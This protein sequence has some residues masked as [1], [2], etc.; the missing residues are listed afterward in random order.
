MARLRRTTEQKENRRFI[1]FV[2]DC[3]KDHHKRQED[4]A[5]YMNISKQAFNRR[6]NEHTPWTLTDMYKV[7]E[8]FGETY[9]L[10][11]KR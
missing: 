2:E 3:L 6:M 10:G 5:D 9:I 1:H 11:A 4:V 7:C 8:F